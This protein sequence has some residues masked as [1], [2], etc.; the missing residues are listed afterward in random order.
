MAITFKD[1]FGKQE[2]ID[3]SI[4]IIALG[5]AFSFRFDGPATLGNWFSN[6]ILVLMLVLISVIVHEAVHKLIGRKFLVDVKTLLWPSG[7]IT[8]LVLSII[9][10]GWF[11]FAAPW[12]VAMKPLRKGQFARPHTTLTLRQMGLIALA[13]PMANLG[14]ATIAKTLA[15]GLGPVADKLILINVSLAV[16]NLFPFF[17]VIPIF[18]AQRLSAKRL[19]APYVEGEFVFFASRP[20]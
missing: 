10:F 20:L 14:L 13:G 12:A 19:D 3:L 7:I 18:I 1:L 5:F 11:V 15:P 17:T 4:I 6:L 16:F 2:L 8:L 9:T